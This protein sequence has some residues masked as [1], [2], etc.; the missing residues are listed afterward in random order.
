MEAERLD[1]GDGGWTKRE[2]GPFSEGGSSLE[3][4]GGGC[5]DSVDAE[6]YELCEALRGRMRKAEAKNWPTRVRGRVDEV[7]II[8]SS[9]SGSGSTVDLNRIRSHLGPTN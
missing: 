8:S 3:G 1:S 5:A 2:K 9:S 4:V 6:A 7:S